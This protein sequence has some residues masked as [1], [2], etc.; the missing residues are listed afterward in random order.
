MILK[1]SII[2][3]YILENMSSGSIT[4]DFREQRNGNLFIKDRYN[5]GKYQFNKTRDFMTEEEYQKKQQEAHKTGKRI[6]RERFMISVSWEVPS[7]VTGNNANKE[8]KEEFFLLRNAITVN[9][10]YLFKINSQYYSPPDGGAGTVSAISV[11]EARYKELTEEQLKES[12]NLVEKINGLPAEKRDYLENAIKWYAR[13]LEYTNPA[14]K[15]ASYWIGLETLSLWFDG[16]S[17][18][19]GL[20]DECKQVIYNK[21]INK[22]MKDFLKNIGVNIE[23]KQFNEYSEIRSG[24]FHASVDDKVKEKLPELKEILKDAIKLSANLK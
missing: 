10:D 4:W 9:S 13:G 21:S 5:I 12:V 14:N 23:N 17:K 3:I 15:Y 6:D 22:R 18:Q 11:L 16:I 7:E 8:T 24:L 1:K 20:C 2:V 19:T